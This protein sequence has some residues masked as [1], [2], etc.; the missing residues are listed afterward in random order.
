MGTDGSVD[1]SDIMKNVKCLIAICLIWIVIV[2]SS[3]SKN[4]LQQRVVVIPVG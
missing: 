1:M 4:L 3:N 2:E